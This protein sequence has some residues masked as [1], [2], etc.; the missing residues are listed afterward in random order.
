MVAQYSPPVLIALGNEL[1]TAM[2]KKRPAK[3]HP[4]AP[5]MWSAI[6]TESGG[7][8]S[9]LSSGLGE[10]VGVGSCTPGGRLIGSIKLPLTLGMVILGGY[11]AITIPFALSSDQLKTVNYIIGVLGVALGVI[12]V[13]LI[14]STAFSWCIEIVASRT[15][16][17]LDEQ[18]MPL[19]RR[20]FVCTIYA[21][22]GLIILDQMNISISPLIA[23]LGLSGLAVA[24]AIQP[25]LANVFAA[26][27]VLAEGVIKPG[28]YIEL[29][30]VE[31]GGSVIDVSWRSTR[32]RTWTNN[33]VVI[34]NSSF[35]ETIITN[36]AE[37]HSGVNVAIYCGV[38]YETNL[39]R[40][41]QVCQEVMDKV[42]RESSHANE[43]WGGFLWS[44][45][46]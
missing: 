11:L 13:A 20:M 14:T 29:E 33:L 21:L 9:S 41:E 8:Y 12:T 36:Y 43:K 22:G 40:L 5:I 18:L 16:S 39:T 15:Q 23:G 24:L 7:L 25:T 30:G 38:T 31:T 6:V 3:S 17:T 42:I 26:T 35:A 46:F 4:R 44:Q 32:I 27:Y 37:P 2:K 1:N 45:K 34:P 10:G 19:L 28:D